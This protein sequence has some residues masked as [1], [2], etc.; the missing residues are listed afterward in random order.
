MSRD[1]WLYLQDLLESA[2]RVQAYT[3]NLAK[4]D[5]EG[6]QMVYD[7]VLRN[8]EIIGEAAKRLPPEWKEAMPAIPWRMVCG[9]R[10]HIA[11]GYFGLDNDVVWDV[12]QEEVPALAREVRI[13]RSKLRPRVLGLMEG[14]LN[15]PDDIND[16]LPP[17]V[18]R[19]FEGE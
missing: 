14:E 9:F 8:L 4:E 19:A 6:N 13:L 3:E 5:F 1:P 16:E 15:T 7:A 17:E 2:S 11:H 18:Q 12:I 10:D